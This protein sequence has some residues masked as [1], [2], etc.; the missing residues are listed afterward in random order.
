LWERL[1]ASIV[2]A[3]IPGDC[4]GHDPGFAEDRRRSHRILK[5]I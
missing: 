5:V 4:P 1:S 2:A 3:G